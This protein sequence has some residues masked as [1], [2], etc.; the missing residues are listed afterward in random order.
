M[1][2]SFSEEFSD[3]SE[4]VEFL[5]IFVNDVVSEVD[6]PDDWSP[7]TQQ[8]RDLHQRLATEYHTWLKD[9]GRHP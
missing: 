9:V 3:S 5:R 2:P 6:D 8:I 4:A 7:A 1:L